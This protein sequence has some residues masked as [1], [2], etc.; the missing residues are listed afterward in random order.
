MLRQVC[1][2]LG[3]AALAAASYFVVSNY[4]IRSVR[5]VGRSM[6]PTLVDSQNYLLNTWVYY[7]HPPRNSDIV[8]LRDPSDG[9]FSVKRII[10]TPGDWVWLKDGRVYLN[11]YKL[12]EPYLAPGTVTFTDPDHHAK[13]LRCGRDQFF[14]LGDNR[15]NSV[16]SRTYGLV[17]RRNILG[18]VL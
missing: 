9:G 6:V 14:V 17:P 5:V 12:K 8:V 16:D 3:V 4:L 15:R 10:A 11:G 2:C 13:L 7:L 18:P 1:Q